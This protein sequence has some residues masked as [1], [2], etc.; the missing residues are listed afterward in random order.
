MKIPANHFSEFHSTTT[1]TTVTDTQPTLYTNAGPDITQLNDISST[2]AYLHPMEKP[3]MTLRDLLKPNY[4]TY[5]APTNAYEVPQHCS[6]Y[7]YPLQSSEFAAEGNGFGEIEANVPTPSTTWSNSIVNKAWGLSTPGLPLYPT[8]NHLAASILDNQMSN[9]Y[10]KVCYSCGTNASSLWT[11]DANGYHLCNTCCCYRK[12][13]HV[14]VRPYIKPQRLSTSKRLGRKCFNCQ[15]EKTS[16][17]RRNNEG[18]H[19]CNS[20]G[21]Y[22]KMHGYNRPLSMKKE[23]IQTRKRKQKIINENKYQ[24]LPMA[25]PVTQYNSFDVHNP[26]STAYGPD[27]GSDVLLP[28]YSSS[29]VDP[30][31]V[32]KPPP[33]YRPLYEPITPL[34]TSEMSNDI[35][36]G[37]TRGHDLGLSL[38]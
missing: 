33:P 1:P 34:D 18:E 36:I 7:V 15:T 6:S 5:N 20:C 22:F 3:T 4:N 27:G 14:M 2:F 13:N 23:T 25:E 21:L 12:V 37:N 32:D 24:P 16:L 31:T 11:T 38:L 17:W 30:L 8:G 10:P 9:G 28:P 29:F 35:P 26:T 19:V